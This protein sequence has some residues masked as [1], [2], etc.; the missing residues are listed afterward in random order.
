MNAML[1]I[2]EVKS[3]AQGGAH[4]QAPFGRVQNIEICE[5]IKTSEPF[6]GSILVRVV[7]DEDCEILAGSKEEADLTDKDGVR[8]Y[9]GEPEF[10]GVSKGQ[11]ISVRAL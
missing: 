3:L 6:E 8:L 4:A 7:A 2:A 1:N 9:A 5:D 10:I 11:V